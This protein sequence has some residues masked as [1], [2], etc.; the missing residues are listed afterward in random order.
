MVDNKIRIEKRLNNIKNFYLNVSKLLDDLK[1]TLPDEMINKIKNLVLGDEELKKIIDGIDNNRPPRLF[2]MGRTGV[3]KSSLIN[4]LSNTYV[5]KVSDVESCTEEANIYSCMDGDR[6]L[7][8]IMDTRGIAESEA[9]K[10][11]ISAEDQLLNQINEFNPDVALFMLNCTHRDD[12]DGDIDFMKKL[13]KE[14]NKLNGINLPIIVVVNKCDEM[15]PTRQK[16][17]NSYSKS[18]IENIDQVVKKYRSLIRKKELKINGIIGVS[19][20]IDWGTADGEEVSANEIEFLTDEEREN[21]QIAFDGR[22]KIDELYQM[23]LDA[24]EDVEAQMGF[25]M[26]FRLDE[27][28]RRL[29]QQLIK[30]FSS[31]AATVAA[32][33]IPCADIYILILLQSILVAM[34]AALSGREISLE[35][36]KEFILS[37][38]GVALVGYAF[39]FIAQQGAKFLNGLFPAAGSAVSATVAY[40]GTQ[41]IG[42]VAVMYYIDEKDLEE[43]KKA[44]SVI[45]SI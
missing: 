42:K 13:A 19:S 4:A 45:S 22:Y 31:I 34:I 26:A 21:L 15:A 5:A 33:P 23:I 44:Y 27:L 28:I 7:M 2:L 1:N 17:P 30:I 14:Y 43:V 24:I 10:S 41:S 37:L 29:S 18:K 39:R 8:E 38:G 25:K 20:L 16:D 3:G 11:S 6:V 35:T 9:L 32:T 12:V 36:A 40:T